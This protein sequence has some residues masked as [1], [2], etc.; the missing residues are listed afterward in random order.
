MT[1][2]LL[3]TSCANFFSAEFVHINSAF[4]SANDVRHDPANWGTAV[5]ERRRRK[6]KIVNIGRGRAVESAA[7]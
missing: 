7:A 2:A 5:N 1:S 6:A 4:S 3:R